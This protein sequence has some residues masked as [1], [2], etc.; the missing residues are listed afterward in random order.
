[1]LPPPNSFPVFSVRLP[2]SLLPLCRAV[3]LRK[4]RSSAPM[5]IPGENHHNSLELELLVSVPGKNHHASLE[6]ELSISAGGNYHLLT[7]QFT[8]CKLRIASAVSVLS[9]V[10][11]HEITFALACA[12]RRSP[13]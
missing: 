4:D 1:M 6:L 2:L 10:M 13:R 5:A 11:N 8:F 12:V 3:P 7:A 9:V